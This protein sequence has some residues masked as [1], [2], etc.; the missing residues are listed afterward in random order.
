[1]A[2]EF[3]IAEVSTVFV[4]MV[5]SNEDM[6]LIINLYRLKGYKTTQLMN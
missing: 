4:N 2:I 6:I 5:F 1:M 3:F